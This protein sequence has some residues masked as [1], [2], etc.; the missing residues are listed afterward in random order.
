[1]IPHSAEK[2]FNPI[3]ELADRNA[4]CPCGS[5]IKYKK[6]CMQ[7]DQTSAA[8]IISTISQIPQLSA[9]SSIVSGNVPLY[10]WLKKD[11]VGVGKYRPKPSN[12]EA[13]SPQTEEIVDSVE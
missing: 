7:K 1:M 5:G 4:S 8:E 10:P 9:R 13:S 12:L 11:F 3:K 6:C 2:K